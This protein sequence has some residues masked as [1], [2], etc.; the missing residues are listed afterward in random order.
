M[1]VEENNMLKQNLNDLNI[2]LNQ[3]RGEHAQVV[4][5]HNALEANYM[6][7]EQKIKQ[8]AEENVRLT[9]ALGS[10]T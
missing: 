1:M 7:T 10:L 6:T 2:Q 3:S 5:S 8:L 9:E 4:A